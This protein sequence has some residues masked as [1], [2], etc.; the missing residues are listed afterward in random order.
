[1]RIVLDTTIL[2]RA[3]ESS[4]GLA[5]QLLLEIVASRHTLPLSNEILYELA[6]VLRYPR[7][8]ALH[9][10]PESRIYD[11]IGFLREV[12]ELVR[13]NPLLSIPIRDV[14]DVV[15][16]QTAL[17]GEADVICTKDEDFYDPGLT[18]FLTR[19][20]ISV[21]DDATLMQRMRN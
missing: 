17:I 21:M 15:V 11:Y 20:G 7:M 1:M 8:Q 10:L 18:R 16:V 19:V 3:N 6:R 2:V 14:N 5:R 13:L 9:G 12:S 4:Q